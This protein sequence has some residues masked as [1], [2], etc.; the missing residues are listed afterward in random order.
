MNMEGEGFSQ[1][2]LINGVECDYDPVRQI[3]LIY[4]NSCSE[5]NEVEVFIEN[6]GVIFQGFVCEKCGAWNPPEE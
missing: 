5:R 4:C 2:V 1:V 6:G 3:A